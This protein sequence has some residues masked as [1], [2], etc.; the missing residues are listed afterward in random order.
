MHV[1][2]ASFSDYDPIATVA[3]QAMLN[4][5][6]DAYLFPGRHAHPEAYHQLYLSGIKNHSKEPQCLVIVAESEITDACWNGESQIAGYCLWM[7]EGDSET[8]RQ[9]WRTREPFSASGWDLR[10]L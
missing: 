6:M 7:R 4:D 9:R 2:L 3:T 1:H 8:T 5:E 10:S